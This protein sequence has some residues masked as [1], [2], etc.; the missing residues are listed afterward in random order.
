MCCGCV[1]YAMEITGEPSDWWDRQLDRQ[2]RVRMCS[3]CMH[4]DMH[5]CNSCG[6]WTPNVEPDVGE[7][8][9]DMDCEAL[10]LWMLEQLDLVVRWRRNISK[11][12]AYTACHRPMCQAIRW[13][14]SRSWSLNKIRYR[15]PQLHVDHDEGSDL[16]ACATLLRILDD[17]CSKARRRARAA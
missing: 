4:D 8:R 13:R 11:R 5:R 9:M 16:A 2:A 14:R 15:W 10:A 7:L 6:D 17:E 1:S 12:D 3:G